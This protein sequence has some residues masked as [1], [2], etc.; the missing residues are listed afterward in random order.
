MNSVSLDDG[1]RGGFAHA[2]RGQEC[3]CGICFGGDVILSVGTRAWFLED[4]AG[5]EGEEFWR[6]YIVSHGRMRTAK[7]VPKI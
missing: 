6:R 1:H 5:L 4:V 7:D 2:S 3:R